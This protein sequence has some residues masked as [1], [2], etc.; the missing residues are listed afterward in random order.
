MRKVLFLILC[1]PA[2]VFAEAPEPPD[3]TGVWTAENILTE[4]DDGILVSS[5]AAYSY[6]YM[7]LTELRVID[8]GFISL[9]FGDAEHRAFYLPQVL[10]YDNLNLLCTFT[11][12]EELVLKLVR[13]G[14][15]WKYLLR[16]PSDSGLLASGDDEQVEQVEQVEQ[17]S[18]E[19]LMSG[20]DEQAEEENPADFLYIGT[21]KRKG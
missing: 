14:Q 11:G 12:G 17:E 3:L 13:S 6:P 7:G 10:D 20:P 16:V 1:L 2:V 5:D 19:D 9:V 18:D 4:L 8:S 15:G 21:I